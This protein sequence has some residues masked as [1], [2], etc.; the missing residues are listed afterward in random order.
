[1]DRLLGLLL[2]H[3]LP[4][5]A[6]AVSRWQAAEPLASRHAP[7]VST[8]T[9]ASARCAV[10][11]Q[12]LL[13]R[14]TTPKAVCV[15]AEAALAALCP[16]SATLALI[17]GWSPLQASSTGSACASDAAVSLL[18]DL[19][20]AGTEAAVCSASCPSHGDTPAAQPGANRAV[21][22]LVAAAP[23][24]PPSSCDHCSAARAALLGICTPL[25][26]QVVRSA[27]AAFTAPHQ[28]L[29]ASNDDV[30]PAGKKRKASVQDGTDAEA[31]GGVEDLSE[32]QVERAAA[33]LQGCMPLLPY[34]PL[35][36][37]RQLSEAL[38][39]AA[40]QQQ[41]QQGGAR[42]DAAGAASPPGSAGRK[43]LKGQHNNGGDG[44]SG[45][46]GGGSKG[47]AQA[48]GG[49]VPGPALVAAALQAA[50]VALERGVGALSASADSFGAAL[51]A[52]VQQLLPSLT[53]TVASASGSGAGGG[54]AGGGG[55]VA[56]LRGRDAVLCV[57]VKDPA[58]G[59]S[60]GMECSLWIKSTA[61]LPTPSS[62]AY[63]AQ[64]LA[65]FPGRYNQAAAEQLL[66]VLQ[67]PAAKA[68]QSGGREQSG[69]VSAAAQ[70]HRR[71]ALALLLPVAQEL[72]LQALGSNQAQTK[73]SDQAQARPSDQAQAGSTH[74]ARDKP[75]DQGQS[76][77]S[78]AA[79]AKKLRSL[80]QQLAAVYR[81]PLMAYT[82]RKRKKQVDDGSDAVHSSGGGGTGGPAG[83]H[84]QEEREE[85][86]GEGGVVRSLKGHAVA[87]LQA[88]LRLQP[89]QAEEKARLLAKLL[90]PGQV[91]GRLNGRFVRGSWLF[92]RGSWLHRGSLLFARAQ[93]LQRKSTA[94][95]KHSRVVI[96]ATLKFYSQNA[97][98]VC[99]C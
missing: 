16:G 25:A 57:L 77:P 45:S 17:Q 38:L 94:P 33:R 66:A 20:Q 74:Q 15:S 64:L 28:P 70:Q 81:D 82:Q 1:M 18:A 50:A 84:K 37:L 9:V 39:A 83:G 54:G 87:V 61:A 79:Q 12:L 30:P 72:L 7:P 14:T 3:E 48:E 22:R 68:E 34:A 65:A 53:D 69:G 71:R 49:D 26:G 47:H 92:V 73:P 6:S 88:C 86:E 5:L 35:Q 76:K 98:V 31:A 51:L 78:D 75:I 40:L 4:L 99:S 63:V 56:A 13:R 93:W 2:P 27:L 95:C 96:D 62:A 8:D 91:T 29:Q 60:L 85:E 21:A 23:P 32:G 43:R 97:G 11:R 89:L 55:S 90:P 59:L 36:Q 19:C 24:P 80:A 44:G 46:G 10:L 42:G 41:Q 52:S 67:P 58:V